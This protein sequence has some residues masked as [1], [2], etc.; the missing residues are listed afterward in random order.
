MDNHKIHTLIETRKC[1][2]TLPDK[3]K[4]V[5]TPK[6][7]SRLNIIESFSSKMM[8]SMLGGIRINSINKLKERISQYIN[9]IN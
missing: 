6:H 7:V 1:L 2:K 4:F 8:R 5:F 9:Q 3:F